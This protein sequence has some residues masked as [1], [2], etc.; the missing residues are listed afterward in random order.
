MATHT[1][2]EKLLKIC[3]N[4]YKAA[5]CSHEDFEKFMTTS[6]VRA[7]AGIIARHDVVK[8]AQYLTPPT[9]RAIFAPDVSTLPPGWSLSPY[10]AQTQYYVRSADDLRGL[11][12]DPEWHEKVS[13]VE[14]AY[15][16]VSEVM[17]MVGWETVYIEDAKVINVD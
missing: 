15:T 4:H 14:T 8:Y 16:N 12:M 5:E 7:A 6:H 3:V 17:I 11:L 1:G 2:T 13:K 10:D 9:A